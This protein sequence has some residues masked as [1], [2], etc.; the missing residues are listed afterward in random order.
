MMSWFNTK[1]KAKTS[2][3]HIPSLSIKTN[4]KIGRKL[5]KTKQQW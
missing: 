3:I 5:N 2:F 4:S 1:N